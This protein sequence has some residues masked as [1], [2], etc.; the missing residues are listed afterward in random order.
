MFAETVTIDQSGHITLPKQ[1]LVALGVPT[2]GKTEVIIEL[3]ET[4]VVIRPKHMVTPITD[5]IAEMDL[6]VADWDQM[7]QEIEA[8]RI[9]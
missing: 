2:S 8:G 9:E 7:E 6:P 5:G 4:G 3:T 1:A